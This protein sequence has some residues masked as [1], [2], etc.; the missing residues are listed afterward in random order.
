MTGKISARNDGTNL[1]V[2]TGPDVCWTP[3]GSAQVPVAY[4]STAKL[5]PALRLA[6]SVRDNGRSDFMLNSRASITT[7][8][9]KGT[10]TG[11]VSAGYLAISHCMD[12]SQTVYSEG[13][14]C[15]RHD[16]PAWIN[17]PDP[18]AVEP[19]RPIIEEA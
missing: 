18:G 6:T 2:S 9:E 10:L 3:M 14:A 12:G 13:W 17:R 1:I 7:G 4:L 5:D 11:M 15:A 16:D 8:H 19:L